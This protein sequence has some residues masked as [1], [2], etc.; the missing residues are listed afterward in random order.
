MFSLFQPASCYWILSKRCIFSRSVHECNS[1]SPC[2]CIGWNIW[3][4]LL[5]LKS[6]RKKCL[7]CIRCFHF[8]MDG[9]KFLTTPS[10]KN[11]YNAA[12]VWHSS[13]KRH[14]LDVNL[15]FW[16]WTNKIGHWECQINWVLISDN[17]K[18]N[19]YT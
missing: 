11:F 5:K 1:N 9:N 8:S 6:V 4:L 18:R 10:V 13:V 17:V 16:S 3:K 19:R 7:F 12:V 15:I 14:V 2:I